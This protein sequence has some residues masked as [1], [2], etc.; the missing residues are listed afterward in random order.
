MDVKIALLNVS[1]EKDV[2]LTQ[3][4]GFIDPKHV[5]KI[6]KL[7]RSIYRLKQASRRWTICFDKKVKEFSFIQ[8][9]DEPDVCLRFSGSHAA[10]LLLYDDILLI[11]NNIPSL[12]ANKIL[13]PKEFPLWMT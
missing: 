7:W 9:E 13:L 2:Y 12:K 5:G 4:E 1:L 11:G 10:F 8:N 3:P 6:C